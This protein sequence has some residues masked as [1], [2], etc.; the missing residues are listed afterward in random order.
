MKKYKKP[1]FQMEVVTD[2][3]EPVYMRCSGIDLFD[4]PVDGHTVQ[5]LTDGST[6]YVIQIENGKYTGQTY[7]GNAV[8]YMYVNFNTPVTVAHWYDSYT[9]YQVINNGYTVVGIRNWGPTELSHNTGVGLAGLYV[10][11]DDTSQQV[12]VQGVAMTLS[13]DGQTCP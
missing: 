7:G 5:A 11:P 12:S 9:T 6:Q 3:N 2:I 1:E 4:F 13:F 8:T 10:V